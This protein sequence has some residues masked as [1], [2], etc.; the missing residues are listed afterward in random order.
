MP[1]PGANIFATDGY[2]RLGTSTPVT[3]NSATFTTVETSLATVTVALVA[4]RRYNVWANPRFGSTVAADTMLIRLREDTVTG[5]EMAAGRLACVDTD[6]AAWGP[7]LIV[8][9]YVAPSSGSKTFVLCAVRR[10]GTG[11]VSL[12][13]SATSPTIIAVEACTVGT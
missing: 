10:T 8:A 3:A 11:S 2:Y 7:L 6:A 4:G 12:R 13:A 1:S 9:D 5:T